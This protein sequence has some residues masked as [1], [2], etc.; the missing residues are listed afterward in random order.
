MWYL[1]AKNVNNNTNHQIAE[2]HL[3]TMGQLLTSSS[4]SMLAVEF[5]FLETLL[6][7][8]PPSIPIIP[9]PN[10]KF[11]LETCPRHGDSDQYLLPYE[12]CTRPTSIHRPRTHAKWLDFSLSHCWPKIWQPQLRPTTTQ[13]LKSLTDHI[14]IENWTSFDTNLCSFRWPHHLPWCYVDS[15]HIIAV[16]NVQFG[17]LFYVL[18]FGH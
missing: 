5:R 17:I 4:F 2:R 3:T 8:R 1:C 16:I 9:P 6:S 10:P 7:A 15:H 14:Q 13:N 18:W 12:P 11:V